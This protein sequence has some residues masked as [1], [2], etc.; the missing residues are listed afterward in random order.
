MGNDLCLTED[1]DL[2]TALLGGE[3]Q[4]IHSGENK[5]QSYFGTQNGTKIRLKE[6]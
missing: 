6:I 3:K 4:L 5:T 2:Y 1:I